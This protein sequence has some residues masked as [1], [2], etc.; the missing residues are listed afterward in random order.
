M[1]PDDVA[2]IQHAQTHMGDFKLK[3][4]QDFMPTEEERMTAA[5]KKQQ[6]FS[7]LS[8]PSMCD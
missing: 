6:V 2:A 7:L 5:R 3:T 8:V 4:D 1:N